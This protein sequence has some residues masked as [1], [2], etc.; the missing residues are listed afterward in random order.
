[1]PMSG[2]SAAP[3]TQ[4]RFRWSTIIVVATTVVVCCAI[5]FGVM[6]ARSA[7]VGS[8]YYPIAV[9][10]SVMADVESR[11][12]DDYPGWSVEGIRMH[13]SSRDGHRYTRYLMDGRPPEGRYIIG[14]AYT[15]SDDEVEPVVT[16]DILR[17]GGPRREYAESLSD[18]LSRY[19]YKQRK[20]IVCLS[21]TDGSAMVEWDEVRTFRLMQARRWGLDVLYYVESDGEWH[22]ASR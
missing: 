2:E 14:I 21:T 15:A 17:P 16:E 3:V 7:L 4:H 18:A 11:F 8:G 20:S 6:F 5:A 1:W 13:R 12:A 9:T 10:R 22:Q 19:Y